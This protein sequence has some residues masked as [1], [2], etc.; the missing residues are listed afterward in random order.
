MR[1]LTV[2]PLLL[3]LLL[4]FAVVTPSAVASDAFLVGFFAYGKSSGCH[5]ALWHSD[6]LLFNTRAVPATIRLLG[7]S[8]GPLLP[9]A[10]SSVTVAPREVASVLRR[11]RSWAPSGAYSGYSI[12]VVH[13]DIPDGV[14]I[15]SRDE[16][17]YIDACLPE[18][19]VISTAKISLPIFRSLV[20][21]NTAQ[22]KLGTDVGST[23]ARQN[24]AIFNGGIDVA[25]ATI[26]VHA[27]CDGALMATT[28]VSIPANTIVQVGGLTTGIHECLTGTLD[29][30]RYCVIT[31][32]Q[33]SFAYVSGVTETQPTSIDDLVPLVELAISSSQEF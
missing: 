22:V 20:A 1:R 8:N 31:V 32:D 5:Y 16:V 18:P 12:W 7:V 14:V 11:A 21:P 30:V 6:T 19:Q 24:V 28:S 9:D 13:V 17:S 4:G 29:Y 10:P 23:P 3:P 25:T 2:K 26:E 15:E 33:P 27:A